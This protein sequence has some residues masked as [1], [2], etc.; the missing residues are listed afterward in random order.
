MVQPDRCV[1]PSW[2]VALLGSLVLVASGCQQLPPDNFIRDDDDTNT[3]D[4]D[5]TIPPDDDD[6]DSAVV[7]QEPPVLTLTSPDPAD[8]P[9][10]FLTEVFP[11][12]F[13]IDDPDSSGVTVT[14]NFTPLDGQ[15]TP[16]TLVGADPVANQ[17]EFDSSPDASFSGF[18]AS[19]EWNTVADVPTS[20][21]GVQI[22]F[23]PIDAEGNE[24][25]CE[26]W[27]NDVGVDVI[28]APP[29]TVG[30]FCQPGDLE[31]LEFDAGE[32][33]IT[34]SDGECLN[35]QLTQPESTPDDFSAQFLLVFVNPNADSVN[36]EITWAD[37]PD[38]LNTG[39]DAGDDDDDDDHG[40]DDDSASDDDDSAAPEFIPAP[41]GSKSFAQSAFGNRPWTPAVRPTS[42][43]GNRMGDD[44][45]GE[46]IPYSSTC[47]EN[48]DEDDVHQ[49]TQTF[50]F[51]TDLEEESDRSAN[52]ATLRALGDTVAIYVDDETPLNID[53]DCADP[54][55]AIEVDPRLAEGFD[56]C[57]LEDIVDI[58]DNNF[59]PTLTSLF[60]D[61]P[62]VDNNCRISIFLSSRMNQLS[63]DSEAEGRII[64]SLAE[65]DVDLWQSDNDLNPG[66]NEQ[67]VLYVY[68]PDPLGLAN[69]DSPVAL[70]DYLDYD[71]AGQI[72]FQMQKLISYAA[73]RSVGKFLLEPD[74]PDDV[75][76]DPAEEDW[77]DDGM[78]LLAADL[79]GFGS[80][81]HPDA[82]IY[83]DRSHIQSP[84][85]NNTLVDFQDLGDNYLLVRYIYDL[86]GPDSVW[87]I[88]HNG[89]TDPDTGEVIT[90]Q[91]LDSLTAV[92]GVEDFNEF[93]LQWAL[94]MAVSG[95]TNILGG[96]LVL[97]VDVPPFDAPT[98]AA[99]P[100][101][102]VP[103]PGE[104]YGANGFQQG[105][106]VRGVNHTYTDGTN[107]SG[108]T[109]L[110][111]LRVRTENLDP[112]VFHQGENNFGTS[113]AAYGITTV[114][115]SGLDHEMNWLLVETDGADLLGAV[116][117]LNDYH[118]VD[119]GAPVT[120]EDILGP[121]YQNVVP[122]GDLDPFGS[123]RRVIGRIDSAV[124]V[125]VSLSCDPP[126]HEGDDDDDDDDSAFSDDD[127]S[128]VD[129]P[130]DPDEECPE[131]G[132]GGDDDD[133][134]SGTEI[135]EI[136]VND[137]DR[138]GFSLA[139][140]QHVGIWVDRRYSDTSGGADLVDP[141]VAV[142]P[143]SDLPDPL[144][145]SQWNFGP[146]PSDG[147]C[148]NPAVYQ[149][150]L[151][152]PEWL[153]AQAVLL[154]LPEY[155]G[156]F[157]TLVAG[158]GEAPGSLPCV[159]DRDQD[160][161]PDSEEAMP[162]SLADQIQQRQA[163]NLLLD[164][165][166]YDSTFGVL[167]GFVGP[168]DQP[169]FDARFIDVDSNEDPDDDLASAFMPYNI[170]GRAL[171]DGEE[172]VWQ[173]VLPPGDYVIVVGDAS[174]GGGV[175]DLSIRVITP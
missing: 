79:T 74:N 3:P 160:G 171:P 73:H 104:L 43:Q 21:A 133:S 167:P 11:F 69:A 16:A 84:L 120:L 89:T 137:T 47:T 90:T 57:D 86:L 161:I 83:M 124:Q 128:A 34:L 44:L 118:P 131:D 26:V 37:D 59:V 60:G 77:L 58:V 101:P 10:E 166:F 51:R 6:D 151:V 142:A 39:P 27:P 14:V 113:A 38:N 62:D 23:C 32:T 7:V 145:Y 109:E 12:G 140:T 165:G 138:F 163:E 147:P 20:A 172:A 129:V 125:D 111:N 13:E 107:P 150:P 146:N 162:E 153:A 46:Q 168:T 31:E 116:V 55:N 72:A 170:G 149:F 122:L 40:D 68:A 114:F 5:D 173:G 4:D 143:A 8:D 93:A 175:Y 141:F 75:A 41:Q 36:F 174:A 164:P 63:I 85:A 144:D 42:T 76:R 70:D 91:G 132:F 28:N 45:P 15:P 126:D 157:E 169:F 50:H 22:E 130:L 156:P 49:D 24:G 35:Y 123:E 78:G 64:K 82:W 33:L 115:V 136:D 61:L 119:P 98:L 9:P 18:A 30:A 117:R 155:E 100:N 65:P 48:L 103:V 95:R 25:E 112:L 154:P 56:N 80:I 87:S 17:M 127:D 67:E 139:G 97:E 19:V 102:D 110:P 152:M 96:P 134:A 81:A 121:V 105:F 159:F 1:L 66:S 52:G 108:A 92:L 148:Y 54:A 71:L 158:D 106:Q 99:V 29:T 2:L 53:R 88:L 135:T 94:A